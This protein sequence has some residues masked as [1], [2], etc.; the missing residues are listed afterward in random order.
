MA[1]SPLELTISYKPGIP[2]I[3]MIFAYSIKAVF[4]R[5]CKII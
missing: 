1:P 2:V 4:L 5:A 3:A